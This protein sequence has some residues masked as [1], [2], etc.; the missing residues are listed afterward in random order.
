MAQAAGFISV[1]T[2]YNMNYDVSQDGLQSDSQG[3]LQGDPQDD[4][5]NTIRKMIAENPKVTRKDMA[6]KADVSL[7]T[8]ARRLE[9]MQDVKYVGSGYSG[10]WKIEKS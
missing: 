6:E 2:L 4:I 7:K 1:L 9:T 10:H 5:E 8:I 3:D